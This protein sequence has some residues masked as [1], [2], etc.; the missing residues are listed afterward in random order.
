MNPHNF[1]VHAVIHAAGQ[2]YAELYIV[3]PVAESGIVGKI[4]YAAL[5]E[6]GGE[7]RGIV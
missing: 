2:H 6:I 5:A 7:F 1:A 4:R 3:V